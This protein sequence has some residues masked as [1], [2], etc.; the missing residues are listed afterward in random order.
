MAQRF[1]LYLSLLITAILVAVF[2]LPVQAEEEPHVIL[3]D[4]YPPYYYWGEREPKGQLIEIIAEAF[5]RMDEPLR[6]NRSTWKR[7]LYDVEHGN[8]AGL[9]AG[10]VSPEREL[11]AI[12]PKEPVSLVENW[13][14]TLKSSSLK[15]ESLEDLRNHRV[16]SIDGYTY[17]KQFDAIE[18]VEKVKV[19]TE[20]QLLKR[21]LS[22]R[23]EIVVGDRSLIEHLAA[24]AGAENQLDFHFSL[25]AKPLYILFSK[26]YPKAQELAEGLDKAL[27]SMRAEGMIK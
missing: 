22:G 6:F 15:F 9:C 1:S 7:S 16:G 24:E 2:C 20:P 17:G 27:R 8:V 26:K 4:T 13:V 23:M 3:V 5:K 21:L 18:G 11:Y 25:G 10:A 12:Y 14:V 19:L